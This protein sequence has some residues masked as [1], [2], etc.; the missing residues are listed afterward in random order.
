MTTVATIPDQPTATASTSRYSLATTVALSSSAATTRAPQ[1]SSANASAA[2]SSSA[3]SS[4][5]ASPRIALS[6]VKSLIFGTLILQGN[7]YVHIRGRY[8]LHFLAG[9]LMRAVEVQRTALDVDV[10]IVCGQG[11]IHHPGNCTDSNGDCSLRI[12]VPTFLEVLDDLAK[13][14]SV[15]EV[16]PEMLCA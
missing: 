6:N 8:A 9:V 14:E 4:S 12:A 15:V 1:S 11:S 13:L 7:V 10:L 16:P 2:L 5:T 3:A